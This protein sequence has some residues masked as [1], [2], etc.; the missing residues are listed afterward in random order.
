MNSEVRYSRLSNSLHSALR[1][2]EECSK[3]SPYI[4]KPKTM[5]K[6]A[7]LGLVKPEI[8][9]YSGKTPFCV[10]VKGCAYLRTHT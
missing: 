2:C 1:E 5:V 7:A 9:T 4:W 3:H 10:T 6:L 8:F